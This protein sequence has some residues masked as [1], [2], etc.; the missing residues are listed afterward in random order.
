MSCEQSRKGKRNKQRT[1]DCIV[2]LKQAEQDR[3]HTTCIAL[4]CTGGFEVY[5]D[6]HILEILGEEFL[7][8]Q[9]SV[10]SQKWVEQARNNDSIVVCL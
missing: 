1:G 3:T 10:Y 5:S 2:M 7:S 4:F 8:S 6:V 9:R